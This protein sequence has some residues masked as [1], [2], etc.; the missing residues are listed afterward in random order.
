MNPQL[1]RE[2]NREHWSRY[3]V[4]RNKMTTYENT[5]SYEKLDVY[6]DIMQFLVCS[7]HIVSAWDSIHVVVDH[8]ERASESV[9]VNLG[10]A[11]RARSLEAKQSVIDYSLGS[12]LEC[13]ACIDISGTKGRMEGMALRALKEQLH[14]IF[15]KLNGLR[16]SWRSGC[17]KEEFQAY[18]DGQASTSVLFN[19]ERLDA[20]KL[21]LEAMREMWDARLHERLSRGVFRRIDD[22][23]TSM[24]LNIAEGNGRFAHLDHARFIEMANRSTTKLAIRLDVC[25]SRGHLSI[26]EVKRIK[27]LLSRIDATT[28][29]LYRVLSNREETNQ[30]RVRDKVRE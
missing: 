19:H 30:K 13:A 3:C 14:S 25:A 20:Y 12:V 5:F 24:V 29:G 15:I 17:I 16:N 7:E 11:C 9:L 2:L 23:A 22:H 21:A 27:R 26:D 28:N 1:D 18:G 4:K 8:F 6:N 10:D